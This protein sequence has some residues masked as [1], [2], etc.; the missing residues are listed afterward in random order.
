M[1]NTL[2]ITPEQ[3]KIIRIEARLEM[4]LYIHKLWNNRDVAEG[5]AGFRTFMFRGWRY[6]LPEE[7][8][9]P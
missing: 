8:F 2:E 6:Y 7:I 9:W 4:D 5:K 1:G 3:W